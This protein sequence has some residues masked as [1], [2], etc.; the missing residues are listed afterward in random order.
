MQVEESQGCRQIDTHQRGGLAP[1]QGCGPVLLRA[2]R[3]L[4]PLP[5]PRDGVPPKVL[6]SQRAVLRRGPLPP[7][8]HHAAQQWHPRNPHHPAVAGQ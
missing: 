3:P 5:A 1:L 7:A 8:H 2:P 6:P 4:Q